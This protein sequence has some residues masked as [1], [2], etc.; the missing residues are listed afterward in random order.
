MTL[1]LLSP[2]GQIPL[3][4]LLDAHSSPQPLPPLTLPE[5]PLQSC[6]G[7]SE[8]QVVSPLVLAHSPGAV[9]LLDEGCCLLHELVVEG[10]C[11]G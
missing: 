2:V 5:A 4:S 10:L 3:H 6:G 8:V 9:V 1:Y 7:I 11:S